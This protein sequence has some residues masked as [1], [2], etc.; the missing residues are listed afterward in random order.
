MAAGQLEET[1]I[2]I[3]GD[4][5][6]DVD[7]TRLVEFHRQCE[8]SVTIG[9]KHVDNPF[10]FGIV[11]VDEDGRVE[12]FL[13][14]PGWGEVF[15]DTINTGIYVIEPEVLRHI[16]E[17]T[18]FD[19]SKEL[20][21][22]LL[23]MGRPIY[24]LAL[25]GYW[26]DVGNLDQY[27]QANVDALE[28]R[29]GL[30]IPGLR[31]RGTVWIGDGVD[32]D[33]LELASIAGPTYIGNYCKIGRDAQIGP[34]SALS[35][36]VTVREGA[37]VARSIVDTSSHVASGARLEGA[38][39]GRSCFLQA[40]ARAH[41][42]AALGDEVTL[43]RDSEILPDARIYPFKEVEAGTQVDQNVV[44]E[45][46]AAST[47]RFV[48]DGM[49]GRMNVDLTP[50]VALR[51]GTALGT[52]L[53]RAD[54]VVV[55]RDASRA[56]VLIAEAIVAGL[57]STGVCVVDLGLSP[58]SL[59]RHGLRAQGY[60]AGVHVRPHRTD[61]ETIEINLFE[62]PGVQLGAELQGTLVRH[63]SRQEF[64]RA[65]YADIG[66]VTRST[67]AVE[68]YVRDLVEAVDAERIRECGFR[69]AVEYSHSVP[70]LVAPQ[71]LGALGVEVIASRA[72]VTDQIAG[73][74]RLD[75]GASI[76]RARQLVGAVRADIAVVVDPAGERVTLVDENGRIVRQWQALLLLS[77]LIGASASD[78]T[79]V[80][81]TSRRCTSMRRPRPMLTRRRSNRASSR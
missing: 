24:G 53:R 58:A 14:K 8:A 33:D 62:A 28:Q 43:G 63:F 6:C 57:R 10:E 68:S 79:I 23:E 70:A 39:V 54:E 69:L 44:W 80:V 7:L 59:A 30:S 81:P 21:P 38:V 19:F 31:I 76:E 66:R 37:V 5:V 35:S 4:A 36:S 64:R 18:P 75:A 60:R 22:R 41:E 52:A 40:R 27:R 2:V 67:R 50:D 26:R 77:A 29:V 12:R 56:S 45:S 49:T 74:T 17:V 51:L 11:V 25:D 65:G 20:F 15:S 72:D 34:Y 78:G 9:L 55:G 32:L 16:P 13:D 46:R 73:E 48:T 61:P 1:F 42:G 71:V 47:R 3:S